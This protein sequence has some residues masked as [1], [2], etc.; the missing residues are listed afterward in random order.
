MA[1]LR[2]AMVKGGEGKPLVLPSPYYVD[3]QALAKSTERLP[4]L[5]FARN[6]LIFK[7]II[8]LAKAKRQKQKNRER[9][10]RK[11]AVSSKT[12]RQLP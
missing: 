3:F 9:K 5:A 7:E 4:S 1:V 10:R 6:T 12:P 11:R 2:T 8:I